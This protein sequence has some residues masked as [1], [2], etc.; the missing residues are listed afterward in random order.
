VRLETTIDNLNRHRVIVYDDARVE[1]QVQKDG[2]AAAVDALKNFSL[3]E[4]PEGA[5]ERDMENTR[6]RR[7]S[8]GELDVATRNGAL[9]V[10]AVNRFMYNEIMADLDDRL[11]ANHVPSHPDA[12]AEWLQKKVK[13]VRSVVIQLDDGSYRCGL[14]SRTGSDKAFVNA[15][16]TA[17]GAGASKLGTLGVKHLWTMEFN[18]EAIAAGVMVTSTK[19]GLERI[20]KRHTKIPGQKIEVSNIPFNS[21]CLAKDDLEKMVHDNS[22][23]FDEVFPS[24]FAGNGL[25]GGPPKLAAGSFQKF[26]NRSLNMGRMGF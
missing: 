25:T 15:E 8:I 19:D 11:Q 21:Q 2:L 12:I 14:D 18:P 22:F 3:P 6:L 10:Q 23:T 16:F 7:K 1:K 24:L 4:V 17:L 13:Y 20:Y 5:A 26:L 9:D